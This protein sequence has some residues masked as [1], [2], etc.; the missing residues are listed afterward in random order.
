MK[1]CDGIEVQIHAFITISVSVQ[2][3]TSA[4]LFPMKEFPLPVCTGPRASLVPVGKRKIRCPSQV[5]KSQVLGPPSRGLV[6]IHPDKLRHQW[7]YYLFDTGAQVKH[8]GYCSIKTCG[9][10]AIL[11]HNHKLEINYIFLIY[12]LYYNS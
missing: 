7:W 12:L 9:L 3:E 6:T 4:I 1:A 2:L 5:S 10:Y 11:V 8:N